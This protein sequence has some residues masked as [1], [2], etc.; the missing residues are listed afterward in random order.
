MSLGI[1]TKPRNYNKREEWV[2][3]WQ[4]LFA[5]VLGV[6]IEQ[7][8]LEKIDKQ[9]REQEGRTTGGPRLTS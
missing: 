4:L 1:I 7:E 6:Q 2:L 5:N 8:M 3:D 9:H